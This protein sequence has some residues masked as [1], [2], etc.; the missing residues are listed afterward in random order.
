MNVI[1]S[2]VKAASAEKYNISG[3]ERASS[4]LVGEHLIYFG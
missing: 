1:F 3:G 4:T 2:T